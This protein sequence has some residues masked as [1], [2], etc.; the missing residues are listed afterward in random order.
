MERLTATLA[1]AHLKKEEAEFDLPIVVDI[2]SAIRIPGSYL[3]VPGVQD[4]GKNLEKASL[5]MK[6]PESSQVGKTGVTFRPP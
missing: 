5:Y 2:L 1:P 6:L 4:F 3:K